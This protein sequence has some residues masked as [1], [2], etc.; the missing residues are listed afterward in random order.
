[1]SKKVMVPIVL[2]TEP[3]EA[4]I[5]IDILRRA[6]ITVIIASESDI[7]TCARDIKIIPEKIFPEIVEEKFDAIIIP[8]GRQGVSIL[9][10]CVAFREILTAHFKNGG[11]IGAVCAAPTLLWEWKI[12]EK[13]TEFTSHPVVKDVFPSDRYCDHSPCVSGKIITGSGM[14]TTCA[15]ALKMVEILAD[16]A[17]CEHVA[18]GICM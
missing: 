2:G 10:E 11:I 13:D 9:S 14:G 17:A 4:V 12:Y 8:G 15:F 6:G 18:K 5:I 16:K 3:A 7:A 1:M